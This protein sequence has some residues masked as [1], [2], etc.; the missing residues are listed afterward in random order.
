MKTRTADL[1]ILGAKWLRVLW[2]EQSLF[3]CYERALRQ[4]GRERQVPVIRT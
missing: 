4:A 3:Y 1:F 2:A